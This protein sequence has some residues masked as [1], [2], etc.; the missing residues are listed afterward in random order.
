MLKLNLIIECCP[1]LVFRVKNET[2]CIYPLEPPEW[3]G[4]LPSSAGIILIFWIGTE[5]DIRMEHASII[6]TLASYQPQAWKVG[7]PTTKRIN[8]EMNE[9]LL[10]GLSG[11]RSAALPL[12][13]GVFKPSERYWWPLSPSSSLRFACNRNVQ[14]FITAHVDKK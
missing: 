1:Q 12:P 3:R 8:K 7:N 11:L 4:S 2:V 14:S 10:F 13:L 6:H 9:L 5:R